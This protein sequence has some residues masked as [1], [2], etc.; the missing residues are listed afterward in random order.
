MELG[1]QS[2]TWLLNRYA[3]KALSPV[4]VARAVLERIERHEPRLN[5]FCWLDA[6]SALATARAS[7]ARW[8]RGGPI[9]LVDGVPTSIKDVVLTKG[10]P[11]R[12]GSRTV[13]P[14][15][16]W[17]Q[18]SP[19]T[20][21]LREQ[22][23][24]ILG[25]T[26][27][28]EFGWK[29]TGDSPLTGSTRNPW[30]VERTSGGSSAGAAAGLAAGMFALAVGTDGGGSI[31]I[32]SS[33]C[34]V[35]GIKPTLGRV[36]NYPASAMGI[37]GHCGPMARNVED[38]ALM[39]DVL[40]GTDP[41]DAYRLP[42]PAGSARSELRAG[43]GGLSIA[44]SPTLGHM[45]VDAEVAALVETAVARLGELGARVE[46]GKLELG[47][48]RAAFDVLWKAAAAHII[49]G[50]PAP[51]L[52]L[53]DPGLAKA[54]AQGK[55][56]SAIDYVR[57]DFARTAL[58]S[59]LGEF[60][61]RCDVLVTPS[62]A[63]PALLVGTEVYDPRHEHEWMDWAGFSYPFNMARLPALSLPCGRTAAGLPVGV[64]I[65]GPLY[66]E[67]RVVRVAAAL[68]RALPAL[69]RPPLA[70]AKSPQEG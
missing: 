27:T 55:A 60:F 47:W 31:R 68:E 9:G 52:G 28:P 67:A 30:A 11:T 69:P 18:D 6:D 19:P 36:P 14:D 3:E 45:R 12:R 44:F 50:L 29:A 34:G 10:W 65:V 32:P 54:A 42:P 70:S 43:V 37:L 17:S 16:D 61:T 4:E 62:V 8:M 56:L 49:A 1:Y 2:A 25:K 40:S 58:G 39:L 46:A 7:E 22:G 64:Q 24:V 57:A 38:A 66:A 15:G 20:A 48:T 5:A 41:R 51:K 21:R 35:V 59:Q 33:F 23:A 63:V 13:D 26:T 53:L